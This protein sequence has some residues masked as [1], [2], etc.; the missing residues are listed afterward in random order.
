MCSSDLLIAGG[1]DGYRNNTFRALQHAPGTRLLAGPW[2]HKQPATAV[3]GPNVDDDALTIAWFHQHLRGGEP[4]TANLA[5]VFVREPTAPEPDLLQMNGKW[6]AFD[7]WPPEGQRW[8]ELRGPAGP[9]RSLQVRGDVGSA[10]WNSCG[11]GLPWGQPLDQR[12]DNALSL[13]FDWPI[14]ESTAVLGNGE[15]ALRVASSATVGHVSVKWCDVAPDGTSTLVTRGFLDLTQRGVW[16]TDNWGSA[17]AAPTPLRPGEWVDV[18]IELEATTWTLQ[19]GHTVRL[20]VAG[21][22]WPNCWPPAEPF[23][24]A[25]DPSS[26]QLLLPVAELPSPIDDLLPLPGRDHLSAEGVE[27]RVEHDVLRRE[28]WAHT[29]YG[30][31]YEGTHGTV[32]TDHYEGHVGI[33]TADLSSGWARGRTHYRMEYPEGVCE[34]EATLDMHSTR[35]AFH[36]DIHL[37]TTR[38]GAPFGERRWTE[39][40]AR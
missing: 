25:V 15:V 16:P 8:L 3:P 20:A 14:D 4:A 30:G 29:L 31:T 2:V 23:S 37:T 28:T 12:L 13:T 35:E 5:H 24:L 7:H 9:T 1:A 11:G 33:S 39:R 18:R 17:N 10:A 27:W 38:D 22:D 40:F 19:P 34:V 36:V 26:V 32:V 6:V 21:T